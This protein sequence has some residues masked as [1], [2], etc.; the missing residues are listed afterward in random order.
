VPEPPTATPEPAAPEPAPTEAMTETAEMEDPC[1]YGGEIK[2]IE[3][4]D[5]L[6]VKFSLCFP[7][8]AFP[9]KAADTALGIWPSE[10]L[11]AGAT[12]G[13]KDWLEQPVGTGPYKINEWRKGD[14]LILEANP[15]YWG[16]K[17]LVNTLVFR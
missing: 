7:D 11:T 1:A 15:E 13:A 8:P 6:T 14:Q 17:A 4:V 2:A 10:A 12:S 9:A 16:D 5:D 3:A